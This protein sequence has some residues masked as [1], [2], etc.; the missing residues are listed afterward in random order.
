MGFRLWPMLNC[1]RD[2]VAGFRIEDDVFTGFCGSKFLNPR[3]RVIRVIVAANQT[4][5]PFFILKIS[6]CG[7]MKSS[8]PKLSVGEESSVDGERMAGL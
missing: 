2:S 6:Y 1:Q 8:S 3:L 7:I 4:Y 5:S